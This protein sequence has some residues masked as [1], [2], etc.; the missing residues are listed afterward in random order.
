MDAWVSAGTGWGALDSRRGEDSHSE[1]ITT[2]TVSGGLSGRLWDSE[3]LSLRLKAEGLLTGMATD[4]L[5]VDSHRLRS[6]ASRPTTPGAWGRPPPLPRPCNSACAATAATGAGGPVSSWAAACAMPAASLT[7]HGQ[8]RTL[9]GRDGYHEWGVQGA[10]EWR[11]RTWTGAACSCAWRPG[12]GLRA[13]RHRATVD[14]RASAHGGRR[15]RPP[16]L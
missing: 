15:P 13:E 3:A 7:L 10:A 14:A 5:S 12:S 16:G 11:A 4:S 6:R 2:R 8:A 9:I 1:D